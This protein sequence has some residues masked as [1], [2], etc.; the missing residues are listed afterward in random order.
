[1]VQFAKNVFANVK[2][3]EE[4]HGETLYPGPMLSPASPRKISRMTTLTLSSETFQ[5]FDE[6]ESAAN[7]ETAVRQAE[8]VWR[9][10]RS[11]VELLP[12]SLRYLCRI[13]VAVLRKKCGSAFPQQQERCIIADIIFLKVILPAM[14]DP[15]EYNVVVDC[16]VS[17]CY[18]KIAANAG[19]ILNHLILGKKFTVQDPL[20]KHANGFIESS[21]YA[22]SSDLSRDDVKTYVR[23]VLDFDLPDCEQDYNNKTG[24]IVL[25]EGMCVTLLNLQTIF[26][27]LVHNYRYYSTKYK[28]IGAIMNRF[29]FSR[30]R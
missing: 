24:E 12:T 5:D 30:D 13:I 26:D 16:V 25:A 7:I 4:D 27:I 1:M 3:V 28:P 11:Y 29:A 18:Q 22:R 17:D 15:I 8:K 2:L 21:Q 10:L 9:N 23:E 14:Q 19:N 6:T 20:G